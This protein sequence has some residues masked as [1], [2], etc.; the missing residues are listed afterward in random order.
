MDNDTNIFTNG[1]W[2]PCNKAG[3]LRDR[4][5]GFS[6]TGHHFYNATWKV[7]VDIASIDDVVEMIW[8][9]KLDVY[10]TTDRAFTT[11]VIRYAATCQVNKRLDDIVSKTLATGVKHVMDEKKRYGISFA[12]S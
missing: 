3:R 5:D 6:Q 10:S 11:D 7:L 4:R 8:R 9:G 1:I 12:R 2:A